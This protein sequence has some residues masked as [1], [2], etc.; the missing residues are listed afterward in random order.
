MDY[1]ELKLKEFRDEVNKYKPKYIKNGN[2]EAN[3]IICWDDKYKFFHL[4]LEIFDFIED[5][6]ILLKEFERKNHI[7]QKIVTTSSFQKINTELFN[8][9]K[10][11]W[12]KFSDL[13]LRNNEFRKQYHS[14]ECDMECVHA[15]S[16]LYQSVNDN[17]LSVDLILNKN[18]YYTIK[19][20]DF[21]I[22]QLGKIINQYQYICFPKET[23][24][25]VIDYY[26]KELNK[27]VQLLDILRKEKAQDFSI[28]KVFVEA[29]KEYYLISTVDTDINLQELSIGVRSETLVKSV[30]NVVDELR[31][32]YLSI[33][34]K[35][36]F[37]LNM[38]I[39]KNIKSMLTPAEL[40]LLPYLL[41]GYTLKKCSNELNKSQNTLKTQKQMILN[42]L[43]ISSVKELAYYI[44][45]QK[46]E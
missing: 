21:P 39:P 29:Y 12:N 34:Y 16:P 11:E 20:Y 3:D 5:N 31:N 30:V 33:L 10:K 17:N 44:F 41:K 40:E 14:I 2:P 35:N 24:K 19:N 42:K 45:T 43:S 6:D 37:E 8:I 9:V 23:P 28:F 38:E 1:I 22:E 27:I 36:N 46:G 15:T 18:N 25:T 4:M 13:E 32:F 7:L 26:Q